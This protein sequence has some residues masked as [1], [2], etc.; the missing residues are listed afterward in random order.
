MRSKVIQVK[1]S[2]FA[3]DMKNIYCKFNDIPVNLTPTDSST[4]GQNKTVDG[5]TVST[6]NANGLGTFT[7]KFTVP[8]GVRCG[9]VNVVFV[10]EDEIGDEY[11]G[12]AE[13]SA[14]GTLM[15]TTITNT[16]TITQHYNVLTTHTNLLAGDPLAQSFV[17]SNEYDR[18]LVEMNLYFATKSN[19][20]AAVVQIRDMVNGY[21]GSTVYAEKVLQPDEV[22][23]PSNPNN[24]VATRVKLNQPVLCMKGV[25]YCFIVLSDSNAYS[26]YYAQMGQNLLGSTTDA[27]TVNPYA[28]GVMFSSSNASTWSAHQASDLKFE[29]YR[30][31]FNGQ[32][33][34]IFDES[35]TEDVTGIFV[36]VAYQ[37]TAN[38][39]LEWYYRYKDSSGSYI[40]WL[41]VDTLV[42]R[43]LETVTDT[44][45]LKAVITTN[46]TTS[47]FIDAER[48][49]L[50]AFIGQK[51]A[52][53]I[54]THI[55]KDDFDEPY[56]ALKV[57]YKAALP[58]GSTHKVYYQDTANGDWIEL[59][60]G[61]TVSLET[62][63]LSGEWTQYTWNVSKVAA[64]VADSTLAG[65]NF[66]KLR[67]ELET[68]LAYNRPRIK[69]LSAIFKFA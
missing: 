32:G 25:Q 14:T 10:G 46:Y 16:A 12:S 64:M 49:S 36:D 40:E 17:L 48:V 60:T 39:G 55:T 47:P 22:N 7:A 1:G 54:S 9:K 62:K 3:G 43:D 61:N 21:P 20:R 69:N 33:E 34:I 59:R 67:I 38:D 15:T 31:Q 13:Y 68:T 26:M 29:L 42:F 57:S 50:R 63:R 2:A 65:V 4:A 11:T 41:P 30:S 51:K 53:Y 45:Q 5:K 28:T 35:R 66:F 44:V 52:T 27:V 23:I 56:Q 37:N 58:T 18:T 24:P 19:V 8:S 6:V